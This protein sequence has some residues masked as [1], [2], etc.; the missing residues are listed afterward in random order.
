MP[1]PYTT[2][3]PP[4]RR[5]RSTAP[6]SWDP[7][8]R[9]CGN[10]LLPFRCLRCP[11]YFPN[12]GVSTLAM[13]RGNYWVNDQLSGFRAWGCTPWTGNR[14]LLLQRPVVPAGSRHVPMGRPGRRA[15]ARAGLQHFSRTRKPGPTTSR[16]AT[17]S[18]PAVH[19][20]DRALV[21]GPGGLLAERYW[22]RRGGSSG[23]IS[24]VQSCGSGRVSPGRGRW[25]KSTRR[26][27]ASRA[28]RVRRAWRRGPV[29]LDET[30]R[31]G[32]LGQLMV[33]RPCCVGRGAPAFASG[34]RTRAR[35]PGRRDVVVEAAVVVPG[36][37]HRRLLPRRAP[38]QRSFRTSAPSTRPSVGAPGVLG[39]LEAGRDPRDRREPVFADVADQVVDRE[40]GAAP[41]APLLR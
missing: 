23:N 30:D 28:G 7:Y 24:P 35:R 5:V 36:Q 40:D 6:T 27:A 19:L 20:P 8:A 31:R 29:V 25:S 32:E 10:G 38:H 15:A 18:Y 14:V 17:G 41:T 4:M 22:Y 1:Y 2:P 3:I 9:R 26:T 13:S 16:P 33:T 39:H 21:A 34:S 11:P 37:E 12:A